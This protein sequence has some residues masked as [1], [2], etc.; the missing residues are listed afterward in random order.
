MLRN[1]VLANELWKAPVFARVP[2]A[3]VGVR[4]D[5]VLHHELLDVLLVH[6]ERGDGRAAI[7]NDLNRGFDRRCVARS[8]DR[9]EALAEDRR[10]ARRRHEQRLRA[11]AT[12]K[13][14]L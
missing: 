3:A 7:E 8:G 5:E 9:V 6:V 11:S 12:A 4:S 10:V 1:Y 14:V 13:V 2:V